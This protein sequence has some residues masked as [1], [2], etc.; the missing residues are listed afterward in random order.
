MELQTL[1]SKTSRQTNMEKVNSINGP[2][3]MVRDVT[4]AIKV[5][6]ASISS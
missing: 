2:V 3:I 4:L 1:F 5:V 6:V